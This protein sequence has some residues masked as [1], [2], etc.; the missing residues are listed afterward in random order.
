MEK[1]LKI[2]MLLKI[3][4]IAAIHTQCGL[5]A[6]VAWLEINFLCAYKKNIYIVLMVGKRP[7]KN[8]HHIDVG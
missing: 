2:N 6:G 8:C 5:A 4:F 1:R 7:R 3:L